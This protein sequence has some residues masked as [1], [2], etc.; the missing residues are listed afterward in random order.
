MQFLK[1]GTD[2]HQKKKVDEKDTPTQKLQ[3]LG[4]EVKNFWM[5]SAKGYSLDTPL[6][7]DNHFAIYKDG[8]V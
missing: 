6:K 1:I 5:V 7:T 2:A 4:I 8:Y 3:E